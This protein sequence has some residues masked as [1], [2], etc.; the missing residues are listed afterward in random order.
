MPKVFISYRQI[1]DA[2]RQRVRDFAVRIRGCGIE[3]VLD[4][5]FKDDHPGG[6]P[7]GWPK[8]S[9]DQ[10][11]HTEKVLVIGNAPWFRCFDGT[12]APGVGLGAACEAGDLRQRI[13][14]LG[15]VQ[16][17]IRVAYFDR[18][19]ISGISFHLERYD[20]FHAV[21]H[22]TDLIRWLGGTPPATSPP[23]SS[24]STAITWPAR[25]P[26]FIPD[27]A[28]REAEFSFFADTLCGGNPKRATLIAAPS[29]SG[30]TR[31]VTEFHRYGETALG[32][33]SCCLV[34][35]RG[36]RPTDYLFDTLAFKFKG[37][38]RLKT[39]SGLR[40]ALRGV[41]QPLLLI[42]DTFEQATEDARKLVEYTLL[43]DLLD[44]DAVRL[45]LA[46][47][48]QAMPTPSGNAWGSKAQRYD[49]GFIQDIDAWITWA[50]QFPLITADMVRTIVLSTLGAPSVTADLI[51]NLGTHKKDTFQEAGFDGF[52]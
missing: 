7:E 43:P 31:L 24:S 37:D 35:F 17:I 45:L 28:N 50:K 52:Q 25:C 8:W 26:T 32:R 46:G 39:E 15:G 14:K 21:D 10:A 3:V 38:F 6:P 12:E 5:F 18:S 4:Q 19:D 20:R 33:D 36:Q 16:D 27:M 1:D 44:C 9:S 42:F 2:Q 23:A 30:K 22:F 34:D 40:T 49:L 41:T 13:Y 51:R 11:I 29:G 47:Q 48:P